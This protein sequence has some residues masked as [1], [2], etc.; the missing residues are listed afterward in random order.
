MSENQTGGSAG[1]LESGIKLFRE[2]NYQEAL[3]ILEAH[4][5]EDALVCVMAAQAY[6][7]L[8]DRSGCKRYLFNAADGFD[9]GDGALLLA[10]EY[11]EEENYTSA[12]TWA[13]RANKRHVPAAG[14]LLLRLSEKS[15]QWE[16]CLKLALEDLEWLEGY[17]LFTFCEELQTLLDG[18]HYP[19]EMILELLDPV[20]SGVDDPAAKECLESAYQDAEKRI[21]EAQEREEKAR[22]QAAL[23]QQAQ[24]NKQEAKAAARER[25]NQAVREA[26]LAKDRAGKKAGAKS[27]FASAIRFLFTAVLFVAMPIL[28]NT[29]AHGYVVQGN[30]S[31]GSVLSIPFLGFLITWVCVIVMSR[32]VSGESEGSLGFTYISILQF[33]PLWGIG[34]LIWW[35]AVGMD[36]EFFLYAPYYMGIINC[37]LQEIRVWKKGGPDLD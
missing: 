29:L 20:L 9:S 8:G 34:G 36:K 16:K 13:E 10:Q 14:Q 27:S 12:L 1:T 30:G 31:V 3:P 7:K 11:M 2:G 33:S 35:G 15:G 32:L 4:A 28:L 26:K 21:A 25:A 22:E 23:S 6:K 17:E 24:Q 37:F 19:D 5:Q 18:G